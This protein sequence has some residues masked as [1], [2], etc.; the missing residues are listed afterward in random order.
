VSRRNKETEEQKCHRKLRHPNYLSAWL[1]ARSLAE[2]RIEIYPCPVCTGLH[3]GHS[4]VRYALHCHR[5]GAVIARRLIRRIRQHE[6]VM[7]EHQRI[8]HSMT[9]RLDAV[10]A[11]YQP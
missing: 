6:C 7:A 2:D 8:L 5:E 4:K 1:Q 3:L 9:V 11:L 10:L